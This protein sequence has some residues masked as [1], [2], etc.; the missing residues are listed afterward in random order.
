MSKSESS[1]T[2]VFSRTVSFTLLYVPAPVDISVSSELQCVKQLFRLFV[3][4][5]VSFRVARDVQND[6][7]RIKC[8]I[9]ILEYNV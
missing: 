2:S 5:F 3:R 9:N 7:T 4:E 1:R 8:V 6:M